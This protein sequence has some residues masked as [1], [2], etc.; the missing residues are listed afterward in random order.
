MAVIECSQLIQKVSIPYPKDMFPNSNDMKP[1]SFCY[2]DIISVIAELLIDVNLVG[3]VI[4][5]T[6][7]LYLNTMKLD[8]TL[9]FLM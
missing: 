5:F 9:Y 7:K 8:V 3:K 1:M 2:L 4:V 6:M